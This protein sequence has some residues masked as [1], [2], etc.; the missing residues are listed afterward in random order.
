VPGQDSAI[1]VSPRL[2]PSAR[3]VVSSKVLSLA[4][5][6][7]FRCVKCRVKPVHSSTSISSSVILTCGSSAAD[8][9][10]KACAVSGTAASSGVIFR[11]DSV[12]MASGRSLAAAIWLTVENC[13]SSNSSRS[14][15]Y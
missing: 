12:M 8:W 7:V 1:L 10:I 5:S 6:P 4:V 3:I 11:P 9:S 15:K 14:C 2:M 13:C